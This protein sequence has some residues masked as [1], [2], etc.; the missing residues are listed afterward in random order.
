MVDSTM[1][2]LSHIT[3][4]LRQTELMKQS[5]RYQLQQMDKLSTQLEDQKRKAQLKAQLATDTFREMEKAH[6]RILITANKIQTWQKNTQDLVS[7]ISLVIFMCCVVFFSILLK[8]TNISK[9][10]K[11]SQTT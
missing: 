7:N 4:D 6:S 5:L 10:T 1:T 11:K 8:I 2:D 9:I 3:E